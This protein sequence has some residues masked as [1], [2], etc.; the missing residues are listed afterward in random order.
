M[1]TIPQNEATATAPEI[2]ETV[3][4]QPT[5]EST[6]EQPT[7][8]PSAT[9]EAKETTTDISIENSLNN[10]PTPSV[11]VVIS[12]PK[13]TEELIAERALRRVARKT[14]VREKA[15]GHKRAVSPSLSPL[16]KL[17]GYR[18]I[19]GRYPFRIEEL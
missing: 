12:P 1:S 13:S 17:V 3:N 6:A 4:F 2:G 15:E 8:E 18:C 10:T 14:A 7:P 16:L 5:S 9:T 11:N 19:L